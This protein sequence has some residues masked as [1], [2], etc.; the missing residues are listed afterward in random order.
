MSSIPQA[1]TAN[2]IFVV[3]DNP[4][5]LKVLFTLLKESGFKVLVATNGED[6]LAKLQHITPNLILLDISMPNLNG[7]EL[8][9]K[10]KENQKTQDIPVIF[11]TALTDLDYKLRGL[12]LGAVDFIGKPFQK[13]EV[14]SRI[15]LH[16]KLS[17]LQNTLKHQ[18]QRLIEEIA[19]RETVEAELLTLNQQLEQ[20]VS[21]RTQALSQAV[22]QLEQQKK[23]LKYKANRDL[24]T[25]LPN[26]AF[27][28][29]QLQQVIAQSDRDWAIFWLDLDNFKKINDSFGHL[30]GD[31]LLQKVAHRLKSTLDSSSIVARLGGD[32][33]A[34]LYPYPATTG[35]ID[36]IAQTILSC[37]KSPFILQHYILTVNAS[38]GIVASTQTYQD[39][40]E[41]LRDAD[42]ALYH[43]KN[44]GK[45]QYA[46]LT[47]YLKA[48]FL[49][50]MQ[51]ESDLYWGIER[52]EF[53]LHYQ[54][55][56]S[57]TT[58]ELVGFEALIRWQHPHRGLIYPDKFIPIAEET[59][60]VH[61]IDLWVL[62]AACD[63]LR[64]WNSLFDINQSLSISVNYSSVKLQF[65]EELENLNWSEYL[66][67]LAPQN[68]KIEITERGFWEAGKVGMEIL[69]T[70]AER[71]IQLCIDD[72]GTGYSSLSRLHDFPAQ[73]IKI[74]RSFIQRLKKDSEGM[75]IVQ[76]ILKLTQSLNMS[77]IAEGIETSEHLQILEGLN[78]D[79]GQ[80]YFLSKPLD[81]ATATQLIASYFPAN[82]KLNYA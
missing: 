21:D 71:G 76:T 69:E 10:L 73:F 12:A 32:E 37:L 81:A 33:F 75:A 49:E 39:S 70:L 74:D 80:G 48:Q 55:I 78:C 42:F 13:Q 15:C 63:R 28:M 4:V 51:I 34:I 50:R 8:C 65:L 47:P 56:F 45:G 38:I 44:Q 19:S 25:A 24:L 52:D 3:D 58:R 68:L 6:A 20:R 46:I 72:F 64:E 41:V 18:N 17:Q 77:A 59:G 23:E 31:R 22:K 2:T 43:A 82:Q 5:N 36:A 35:N 79:F 57:L 14:L 26:R 66:R 11:L 30:V 27:F 29:K 40:A 61:K 62:K 7:F 16:L 53:C 1:T 67:D 9:G 54:P 60:M